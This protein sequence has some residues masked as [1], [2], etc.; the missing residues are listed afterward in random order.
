MCVKYMQLLQLYKSDAITSSV[1][2]YIIETDQ[3]ILKELMIQ[4]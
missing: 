1:N 4:I 2:S 3:K